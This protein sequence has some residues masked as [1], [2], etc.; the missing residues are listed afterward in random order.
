MMITD[1]EFRSRIK[2]SQRFKTE[3]SLEILKSINSISRDAREMDGPTSMPF[4][5]FTGKEYCGPNMVRLMLAGIENG[6]T[7]NR[8]IGREEL[9][10]FQCS[11]LCT[12]LKV[13]S[14]EQ[15]VVILRPQ[16]L[17]FYYG[18]DGQRYA[19]SEADFAELLQRHEAGKPIPKVGRAVLFIPVTV[20][21][22]C[23]IENFPKKEFIQQ[24]LSHREQLEIVFR[25]VAASG[26]NIYYSPCKTARY[27]LRD[28]TI[29][30]PASCRDANI[31]ERVYPTIILRQFYKATGARH[32][33]NRH[34]AYFSNNA[35]DQMIEDMAADIFTII[36]MR[37]LGYKEKCHT[38]SFQPYN[39]RFAPEDTMISCIFQAVHRAGE[40]LSIVHQ[41]YSGEQPKAQ[42]FPPRKTWEQLYAAQE[43]NKTK[44]VTEQLLSSTLSPLNM[45]PYMQAEGCRVKGV[46]DRADL[47]E[48]REELRRVSRLLLAPEMHYGGSDYT[49]LART[50]NSF[51]RNC[52]PIKNSSPVAV[53]QEDSPRIRMR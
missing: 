16:Q 28:D 29:L 19:M 12:D 4:S 25:F 24:P 43:L 53:K 18:D 5:P 48:M 7:D 11:H 50:I 51:L 31:P 47:K 46:I 22:A 36:A 30:L 35:K 41:F 10:G 39:W 8:W 44:Y 32:R 3:M 52:E 49:D 42:W 33:E 40:M 1:E 26:M 13:P 21:N 2:A 9:S 23:Q 6:Y 14:Q 27:N 17:P 37:Y 15:G 45:N 34:P 20:Y 38:Q